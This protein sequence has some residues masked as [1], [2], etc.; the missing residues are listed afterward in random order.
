MKLGL[1]FNQNHQSPW[2]HTNPFT[3][4]LLIHFYWLFKFS[5]GNDLP[6]SKP[7]HLNFARFKQIY[8]I[9]LCSYPKTIC[10][11][12]LV[13]YYVNISK[14]CIQIAIKVKWDICKLGHKKQTQRAFRFYLSWNISFLKSILPNHNYHGNRTAN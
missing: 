11:H 7:S 4:N 9:V 12:R 10:L 8:I 1:K 6:F 3:L 14:R 2:K 5:I 13:S